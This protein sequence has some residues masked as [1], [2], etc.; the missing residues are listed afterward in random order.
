MDQLDEHCYLKSTHPLATV[1]H[2]MLV[3]STTEG[4]AILHGS[5]S[6]LIQ[7]ELTLPL[8]NAYSKSFTGGAWN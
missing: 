2:V 5:V 3:K 4:V 6:G 8:W 1:L 7:L